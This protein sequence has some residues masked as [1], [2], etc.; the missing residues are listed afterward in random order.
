MKQRKNTMRAVKLLCI[1]FFV[2]SMVG[3]VQMYFPQTPNNL[4]TISVTNQSQ[5][6]QILRSIEIYDFSLRKI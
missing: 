4:S 5:P 3:F 6:K 1:V 2:V